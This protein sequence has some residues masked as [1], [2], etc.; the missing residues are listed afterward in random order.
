MMMI[1]EATRSAWHSE[2][3]RS[4]QCKCTVGFICVG[5]ISLI[6][7]IIFANSLL[8]ESVDEKLEV[9]DFTE[10]GP[11]CKSYIFTS[12]WYFLV[13]FIIFCISG[14]LIMWHEFFVLLSI[15]CVLCG[16]I[17]PAIYALK[18]LKYCLNSTLNGTLWNTNPFFANIKG[19]SKSMVILG[20]VCWVWVVVLLVVFV[21]AII[22]IRK[23]VA[24]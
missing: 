21:W 18:G 10:Q 15:F 7:F 14:L 22:V 20:F 24:A 17:F 6:I 16:V 12:L 1:S 11:E 5:M 19:I 23:K 13:L 4:R 3:Q 2:E 9:M 8:H